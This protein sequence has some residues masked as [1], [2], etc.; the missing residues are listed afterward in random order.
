ME[1]VNEQMPKTNNKRIVIGLV[2]I[3]IAGLLFADNFD[4]LPWN[5]EHYVFT[6]QSVLIII[7]IILLAKNESKTTGIILISIGAFFL[8]SEFLNYPFGIRH[9]FWPTILAV[10]GVLMIVRQKNKH[11][12][13]GREK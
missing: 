1:R 4:I 12:F 5:W 9:I 10:V 8:A 3:A 13:S 2:L 11:L 7:G 6:W